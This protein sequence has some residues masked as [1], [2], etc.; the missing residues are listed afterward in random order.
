MMRVYSSSG[1]ESG[2]RMDGSEGDD[3]HHGLK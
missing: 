1:R 3:N 2:E